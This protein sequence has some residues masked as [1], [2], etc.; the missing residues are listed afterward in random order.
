MK[1]LK[2]KYKN[3][4][5]S[6]EE[7]EIIIQWSDD[8]KEMIS[9]YSSYQPMIRKLLNNPLFECSN[10][11]INKHYRCFPT[12]VAVEGLL[13]RE[14]LIIRKSLK[15]RKLTTQQKKEFALRM[16]KSRGA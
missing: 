3:F 8:K 15:K 16:K 13:P 12:P 10:K 4:F 5:L 9:I 6:A 14:C 11:S 2:I 1:V 7:R